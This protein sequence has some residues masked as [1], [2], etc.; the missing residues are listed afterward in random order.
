MVY[1]NS[2]GQQTE[3]LHLSYYLMAWKKKYQNLLFCNKILFH[4]ES[5][6]LKEVFEN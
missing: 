6:V 5:E 4:W 3:A 2:I 1:C